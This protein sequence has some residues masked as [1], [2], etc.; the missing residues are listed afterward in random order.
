MSAF[1][2]AASDEDCDE[3]ARL[4]AENEQLRQALLSTQK[5]LD[6]NAT[7]GAFYARTAENLRDAVIRWASRAEQAEDMLEAIGAG[8]VGKPEQADNT[9]IQEAAKQAR[10]WIAE[11]PDRRPISAGRMVAILTNALATRPGHSPDAGNMVPQG[12]QLVPV[13]MTDEMAG[14]CKQHR[15][16]V[17]WVEWEAILSAAPQSPG[18]KPAQMFSAGEAGVFLE[19]SPEQAQPVAWVEHDWSG[20]GLRRLHFERRDATVRDEVVNPVWTP[21]YTAPPSC[22]PEDTALLRQ[23]LETLEDIFGKNKVDVGVSSTPCASGWGMVRE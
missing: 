22:H 17:P 14:A 6:M 13:G 16:A 4:Q 12:W 1:S 5:T 2:A 3:I 19:R 15:N 11:H 20:T 9:A 7:S 10:D 23:A 21:L 8:G 18:F